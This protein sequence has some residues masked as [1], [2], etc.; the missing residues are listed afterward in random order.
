MVLTKV[1]QSSAETNV[2]RRGRFT[3]S[4]DAAIACGAQAL[5]VPSLS[6]SRGDIVPPLSSPLLAAAFAAADPADNM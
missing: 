4:M 3:A 1:E 5:S 2:R 6:F